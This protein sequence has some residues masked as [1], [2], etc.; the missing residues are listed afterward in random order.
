MSSRLEVVTFLV[1]FQPM[2]VSDLGC[3]CRVK[4]WTVRK[5]TISDKRHAITLATGLVSAPSEIVNRN[6]CAVMLRPE[7]AS[8]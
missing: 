4:I 3:R 6:A 7:S 5:V 2:C 1:L 8:S